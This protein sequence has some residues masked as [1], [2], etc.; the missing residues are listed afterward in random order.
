VKVDLTCT[1]CGLQ[2]QKEMIGDPS[3]STYMG[4]G[5]CICGEYKLIARPIEMSDVF[6]YKGALR[7]ESHLTWNCWKGRHE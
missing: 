1:Y 3:V 4:F 5:N 6:G 2:W 7:T